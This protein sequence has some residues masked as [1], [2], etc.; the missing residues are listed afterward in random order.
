MQFLLLFKGDIKLSSVGITRNHS[1][2]L[3]FYDFL[4]GFQRIPEPIFIPKSYSLQSFN[5]LQRLRFN[6]RLKFACYKR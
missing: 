4:G 3:M 6:I 5:S 1:L 2:R